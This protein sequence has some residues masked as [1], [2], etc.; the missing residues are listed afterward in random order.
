[1]YVINSS[2]ILIYNNNEESKKLTCRNDHAV[3]AGVGEVVLFFAIRP[4]TELEPAG[5]P[6]LP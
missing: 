6:G 4:S 1:M 2:N 5:A 3:A